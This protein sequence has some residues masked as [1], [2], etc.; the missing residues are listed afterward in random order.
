MISFVQKSISKIKKTKL[1]IIDQYKIFYLVSLKKKNVF[2]LVVLVIFFLKN[3]YK[4]KIY[5]KINKDMWNMINYSLQKFS[6]ND[7]L[8]LIARLQVVKVEI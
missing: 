3:I 1:N 5:I 8:Q 4:Q 6:K 7:I 2:G